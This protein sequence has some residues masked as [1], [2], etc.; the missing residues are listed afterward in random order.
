MNFILLIEG[1]TSSGK[2]TL[3][4]KLHT[5]LKANFSVSLLKQDDYYKDLTNLSNKEILNYNFD[6]P[7]AID[8][9]LFCNDVALLSSGKRIE[10]R[11]Y[12]FIEHKTYNLK[13]WIYPAE[14]LI[15]EGLFVFESGLNA[16]LNVFLDV[17]DDIRF[18]RRLQRDQTE[19]AISQDETIKQYLKTVKPMHDKYIKPSIK[20]ADIILSND[21]SID[22]MIEIIISKLN[23]QQGIIK[24]N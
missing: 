3:S 20:K 22:K 24:S 19:R 9:N 7:E 6:S 5:S 16:D 10:K 1:G 17:D 15:C 23:I 4:Q 8:I 14:I 21:I 13:E 18:I 2:S 11:K 12:D